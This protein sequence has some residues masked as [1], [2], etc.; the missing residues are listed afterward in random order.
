MK[1]YFVHETSIVDE[2]VKIGKNTKIWHFCH[3]SSRAKIGN[4]C[5]I[6]QNVFVGEGVKIGNNVKI[7]NNVSVYS[8][9]KIEDDVFIGPSVVFTNVIKPRSFI[10]KKKKYATTI[11]KKGATLGANSTIICGNNI[12]QYSF[13]GA[14]SV[15]TS[16]V[17]KN[18]LVYGNPA[19]S[20]KKIKK[21]I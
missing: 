18:T 12:G 20:K 14:G 21:I 2:K 7:Q 8:G 3:I 13:V 5:K 9:V 15:V 10:N 6:G 4:N 11:I 1:N 19:K 16:D 17:L